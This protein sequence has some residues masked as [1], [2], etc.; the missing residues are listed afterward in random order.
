ML[1]TAIT[2]WEGTPAAIQGVIAGSRDAAPIHESLGA[3]NPRLMRSFAGGDMHRVEYMIDFD[4]FEACGAFTDAMLAGDWFAGLEAAVA[5]AHPDLRN[6]G[7]RFAY[8][9]I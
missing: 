6:C 4:S 5:A 9:A 7:T 1:V 2:T 3:R 8:N